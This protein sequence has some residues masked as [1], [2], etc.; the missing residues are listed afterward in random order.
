[1]NSIAENIRIAK[2][3]KCIYF[4]DKITKKVICC[5]SHNQRKEDRS[6]FEITDCTEDL[7]QN[8]LSQTGPG[9][10]YEFLVQKVTDQKLQNLGYVLQNYQ[11][12]STSN[13]SVDDSVDKKRKLHPKPYLKLSVVSGTAQLIEAKKMNEFWSFDSDGQT[14]LTLKVE[15]CCFEN[16][17]CNRSQGDSKHLEAI[18]DIQAVVSHGRLNPKNGI[19]KLNQGEAL[20]EWLLPDESIERARIFVRDLHTEYERSEFIGSNTINVR[21]Y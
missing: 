5:H 13:L 16:A 1:M 15:C 19:Y 4:Y 18:Y 6:G 12:T 9:E 20:I 21:C 11:D 2:T 10:G 17:E 14:P 7:V 3:K 8:L